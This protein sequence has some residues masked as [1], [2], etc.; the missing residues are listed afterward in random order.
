MSDD[1]VEIW[2]RVEKDAAGHPNQEWEQLHA[3]PVPDG[4]RLNNIPFFTKDLALDDVV[5]ARRGERGL[6]VFDG[7]VKRS[8][9]STFRIWLSVQKQNDSGLI[10]EAVRGLGGHAEVTLDRLIAIDA[11]PD[12]E[13]RIWDYLKGGQERGDWDLQVGY[14]PDE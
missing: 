14:S 9:H 11:P 8:G 5:S 1:S 4:Y 2:F 12:H 10:M 13:S 3:W 6:L 7:V